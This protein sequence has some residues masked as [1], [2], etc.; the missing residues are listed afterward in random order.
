MGCVFSRKLNQKQ[1]IPT[2]ERQ[3]FNKDIGKSPCVKK[4]KLC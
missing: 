2:F 1:L 4:S 3:V